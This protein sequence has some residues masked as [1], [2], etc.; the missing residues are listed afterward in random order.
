MT[1]V[2]SSQLA[3]LVTEQE[4]GSRDDLQVDS[5]GKHYYMEIFCAKAWSNLYK[6]KVLRYHWAVQ[7]FL[8]LWLMRFKKC[9]HF[10]HRKA[11]HPP[12]SHLHPST[13]PLSHQQDSQVGG[14]ACFS[15]HV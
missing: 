5:P 13:N 10:I 15:V 9:L 11:F 4:L 14:P 7:G 8:L 6:Q 2:A 12:T 1:P 3:I